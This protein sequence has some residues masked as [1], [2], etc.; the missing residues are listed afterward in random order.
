MNRPILVLI[1]LFVSAV[2]FSQEKWDLRKCVDY[3]LEHNISIK[4]QDIQAQIAQLT[5]K[6]S[7][8]SKYPNLNG[9]SNLGINTGRSIDRTT[10]LFTTQSIFYNSFSLQSNV[11]LFNWFSKKNTIAGNKYDAQAANA[12]VD[13]LKND[14]SLNVAAAYLQALLAKA[15]VNATRIQIMQTQAQLNNTKKLVDA[16][17]LPELNLVQL[18]SQLA[19]DSFTL[20]SA[21]GGETQSLLLVKSILNLDAGMPFDVI[22]PPIERIPVDPIA[23][24]QPELVYQLA[25]K[26]L[27]QQRVNQLRLLAAQKFAD[28][29]KGAMYPS[30]GL[31]AS[32]GTNYSNSKNNRKLI[33]STANGVDTIAFVSGSNTPVYVPVFDT[34]YNF[35]ANPYGT[36]FSDNFNNGVG[37]SISV[38]IFNGRSARIN[39]E[40][41][42]LNVKNL[43]LQ[44]ELDNSSLK[45]N[46]YQAYSDAMTALQKFNSS[47]K[48]LE[49]AQKAYDYSQKRYGVG[50]LNTIDLIIGQNNLFTATINRLSAQYEY[51]FKMKVLEFYKGEGLK[52]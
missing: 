5:Y 1:F 4:Q 10:N 14:I 12:S 9:S 29:A 8:L 17:S 50:L 26:N 7:D 47:T 18:E 34:R 38:P 43:G 3:A 23:E 52:L 20:I 46:I 27:P 24:L 11:D 51:V 15:Q 32:L 31:G 28:A 30:I 49:L 36:Q 42:K 25:I 35:F 39:W 40:K 2:S 6:Q 45:Q 19:A 21:I 16:G 33:S 41:Q 13:K 22:A 48:A 37:I 44:E